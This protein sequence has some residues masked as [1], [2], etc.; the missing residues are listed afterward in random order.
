MGWVAPDPL[1][2]RWAVHT[3][4]ATPPSP[5]AP[6]LAWAV[7]IITEYSTAPSRVRNRARDVLVRTVLRWWYADVDDHTPMESLAAHQVDPAAFERLLHRITTAMPLL[8]QPMERLG[9]HRRRRAQ[10]APTCRHSGKD[11]QPADLLHRASRPHRAFRDRTTANS[12]RRRPAPTEQP[13]TR[14]RVTKPRQSCCS[15]PPDQSPTRTLTAWLAG[16]ASDP[17]VAEALRVVYVAV[18][19]ARRLL[20]LAVPASDRERL[21]AH[22]HRLPIPTELR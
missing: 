7:G 10:P 2:A 17:N 5:K 12:R 1:A 6:A 8:D 14:S 4:A 21:L 22:L 13:S 16:S 19:R 20:G 15:C 11:Q 9:T 18:T 3:G